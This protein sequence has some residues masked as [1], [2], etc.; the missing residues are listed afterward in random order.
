MSPERLLVPRR[1]ALVAVLAVLAM[2]VGLATFGP[3]WW[4]RFYHPL[5]HEALIGEASQRHGL[6]PYL[7]AAV[8]L[9]ESGFD[10]R[11]VSDAGAEGLMQ[12]LPATASEVASD[13]GIPPERLDDDGLLLPEV[14]IEIGTYYL[15]L[16]T[17][18]YSEDH[19]SEVAIAAALAAYNAGGTNADRWLAATGKTGGADGFVESID[20]PETRHFVGRVLQARERYANLYPGAFE[21]FTE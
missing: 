3:A 4:Q 19:E 14:N 7:V 9:A 20:F 21:A 2:T 10:E 1:L 12:V 17:R 5:E 8:V 15:S 11:L 6:D 13:A 16:L 18:R